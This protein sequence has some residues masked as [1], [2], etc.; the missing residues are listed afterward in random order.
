MTCASNRGTTPAGWPG[1]PSRA[2]GRGRPPKHAAPRSASE[3]AKA[4]RGCRFA[5]WKNPENLTDRQAD[6]LAWIAKSD[7]RLHRAYLLK[8][9]LRAVFAMSPDHAPESL[10]QWLK[11]AR[12]SRL[13]PFIRLATTITRFRETILAAI[14]HGLSNGLIESVNTKIRLLTRMAFGFKD[15]D[16]LITLAMLSL[17]PHRAALPGRE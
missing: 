9:G 6:K 8:E 14:T 11:W 10:E 4:L 13:Q 12:R 15:P 3:R 17:G 5:L 1:P 16:A 7:P 2:R